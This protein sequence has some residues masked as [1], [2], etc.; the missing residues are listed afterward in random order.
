MARTGPMVDSCAY[1]LL[2]LVEDRTNALAHIHRLLKPGGFFISSTV[3]LGDS[4]I[5]YRPILAVM[6][7]IG[8]APMVKTISRPTLLGDI[9]KAG[10]AD[11]AETDVGADSTIAFVVATK[12]R[13]P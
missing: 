5:P 3:C 4:W 2:H 13:T 12:P 10:F 8:K 6:R 7:W 1:S 11:V 9:T